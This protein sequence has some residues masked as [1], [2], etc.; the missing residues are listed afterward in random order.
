[1]HNLKC[2]DCLTEFK[3]SEKLET[4][5]A[6]TTNMCAKYKNVIFGC[7]TC[8]L[9][10]VGVNNILKHQCTGKK[11]ANHNTHKC[12]CELLQAEIES[13][14]QKN[15]ILEQCIADHIQKK[16]SSR[17][18]TVE[19]FIMKQQHSDEESAV[20]PAISSFKSYKTFRPRCIVLIP[21]TELATK[22]NQNI[23]DMRTNYMG[24]DEAMKL[25]DKQCA[26]IYT[27]RTFNNIMKV[28]KKI[29]QSMIGGV[30]IHEYI[31]VLQAQ[32]EK[33]ESIF[34]D[35][36]HIDKKINQLVMSGMSTVDCK[37]VLYD[38]YHEIPIDMTEDYCPLKTTLEINGLDK[39]FYVPFNELE[40]AHRFNTYASVIVDFKCC[41][42]I[43]LSNR[44]GF[45]NFVYIPISQS[46][47][48]DPYSYYQLEGVHN[49][50]RYW[51]LDVRLVNLT[52]SISS[53]LRL[54]LM[55]MFK[56]I[57]YDV[58]L[59]NDFRENFLDTM[60]IGRE[61]RQLMFNLVLVMDEIKLNKVL[62][63]VV[64]DKLTYH[65]TENDRV[66]LYGDDPVIKK[67][68]AMCKKQCE[69]FQI[70]GI[71]ELFDNITTTQAVDLYREFEFET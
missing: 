41:L 53:S 31:S 64:Y 36:G 16:P 26:I 4:H 69:D 42:G 33:L 11:S 29:R 28:I 18:R 15:K 45:N 5:S 66:N 43:H 14:K 50:K 62:R 68:Y 39:P 30:N 60:T 54:Y 52:Y 21:E 20:P 67:E 1:M 13:L 25:F 63:F 10:T 12:Q 8:S 47:P 27:K 44:Y 71:K 6:S 56:K 24:V 9:T 49:N 70:E 35:R 38:K 37:L 40:L 46:T 22:E 7:K 17:Y 59:D 57:Y 61:V 3:T 51:R 65:P 55:S 34:K 48:D 19:Q 23:A 2:N 32:N 58:Y